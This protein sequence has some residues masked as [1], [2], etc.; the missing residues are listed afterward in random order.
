MDRQW[1]ETTDGQQDTK[2]G[3]ADRHGC[4][5]KVGWGWG[6]KRERTGR[7]RWMWGEGELATHGLE[8]DIRDGLE[9]ECREKLGTDRP[10]LTDGQV[11]W[12]YCRRPG[13]RHRHGQ[14]HL[15]LSLPCPGWQPRRRLAAAHGGCRA[16]KGLRTRPHAPG[17]GKRSGIW[18]PRPGEKAQSEPHVLSYSDWL[19]DPR[20]PPGGPATPSHL[21]GPSSR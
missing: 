21:P 1:P 13:L 8:P 4:R 17:G 12:G 14:T 5:R 15:S 11:S 9:G 20:R 16:D 10:E 3:W 6:H 2:E 19:L 7:K 18:R